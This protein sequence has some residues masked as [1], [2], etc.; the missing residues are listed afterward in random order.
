MTLPSMVARYDRS[1]TLE[2][3]RGI[4]SGPFSSLAC[5]ERIAFH[6]QEMR[7]LLAA[8][9]ALTERVRIVPTLYVL[10][11]HATAWVAKEVA[12]L[13]VLSAG[14]VTLGVG[15]GGRELD[16]QAVGASFARRHARMD[17]QVAELR[18]LWAGEPPFDGADPIGPRP[19]QPGGPPLLAGAQ[20]P[21]ALRR[22]AAWAQGVAGFSISGDPRSVAEAF[23]AADVAWE[24]AGATSKPRRVTGFWYALG[25]DAEARLRQ[26][27][28]DYLKVFGE[29]PAR[30]LAQAARVHSDDAFRKAV[31]AIEALGCDELLLVPTSSEVSELERTT[32]LIERR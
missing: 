13:D 26:Y 32:A 25:E 16:Y 30:G 1:T 31:D 8:A 7:V 6:N 3:C 21:K 27:V 2:W 11:M 19:V 28:Y 22:A 17:D 14:R 9:A 20:G 15:V 23:H 18:R 5:G 10:P 4:D 12:T 29:A 24:S